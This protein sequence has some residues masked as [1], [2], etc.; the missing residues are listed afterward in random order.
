MYGA[1]CKKP[2]GLQCIPLIRPMKTGRIVLFGTIPSV[3]G[4]TDADAVMHKQEPPLGTN[5]TEG[6]NEVEEREGG[7]SR[8]AATQSRGKHL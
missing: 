7:K 2:S 6:Q 5:G 3:A 4:K 8:G 1:S